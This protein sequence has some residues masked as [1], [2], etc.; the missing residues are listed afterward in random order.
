M[1]QDLNDNSDKGCIINY[2]GL[3]KGFIN[4]CRVRK[5]YI[6]TSRGKLEERVK[7]T[8]RKYLG[9]KNVL[10][11]TIAHSIGE[12]EPGD[13]VMSIM[14]L[15]MDR[16][17]GF[18]I[19]RLILEDLKHDDSINRYELRDDG[20]FRVTGSGERVRLQGLR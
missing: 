1:I 19:T 18:R 11:I 15:A 8:G 7:R 5:L 2:R 10:G 14:V 12:L 6:K 3:V 13:T 17:T 20:L 9:E 16:N 4:G